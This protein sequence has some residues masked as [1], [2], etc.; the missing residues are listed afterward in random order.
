MFAF[1]ISG[2]LLNLSFIQFSVSSRGLLNVHDI[3]PRAIM[4]FDLKTA[5]P[6]KS[7]SSKASFVSFS[8]G[9]PNTLYPSSSPDSLGSTL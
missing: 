1:A 3:K 8:I 6:G 2:S 4:F 5:L 9:T 7:N